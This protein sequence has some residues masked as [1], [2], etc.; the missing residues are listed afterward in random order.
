MPATD[1]IPTSTQGIPDTDLDARILQLTQVINNGIAPRPQHHIQ[2]I[3]VSSDRAVI[4]IRVS[5]SWNAPHR[6]TFASHDKF[7]ARNSAGKHPM[8][9]DEYGTL[10][11]SRAPSAAAFTTSIRICAATSLSNT[12]RHTSQQDR[13]SSSI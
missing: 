4:L 6:V 13:S 10:S 2:P 11:P 7:Y 9:L 5:K 8:D 3:P 12:S 1:G